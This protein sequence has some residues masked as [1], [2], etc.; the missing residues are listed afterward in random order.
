[1]SPEA[2]IV[3]YG[4]FCAVG[5]LRPIDKSEFPHSLESG[6]PVTLDCCRV[7]KGSP[8]RGILLST[9]AAARPAEKR[10]VAGRCSHKLF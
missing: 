9:K 7:A 8:Q 6:N 5:F 4:P 2:P 1:M 10:G 3:E